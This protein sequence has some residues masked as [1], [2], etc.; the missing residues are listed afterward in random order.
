M[1]NYFE[2]LLYYCN[3]KY[4]GV[5]KAPWDGDINLVLYLS[6]PDEQEYIFGSQ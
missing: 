2:R 1:T 4:K 3:D 6:E 5:P